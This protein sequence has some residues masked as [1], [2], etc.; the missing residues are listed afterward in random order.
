VEPY[1]I[2]GNGVA[3]V[4][5]VEAIRARGDRTP[6]IMCTD[7][8]CTFY[9]RPCLYYIMLGRIE[10][11]DAWGRPDSFYAE[12]GVDVRCSTRVSRIDPA[13]HAVE[14]EGQGALFY[15]R[16]LLA[17]GTRGRLLPWAAQ[18]LRGIV[19]LNM[20]LDV[21][22]IADLLAAA[23]HAVVAGGGLTSIEL[24]EVCRH[25]GVPATFVI[26]G[27]R[28]LEKQ[29]TNDE[30]ELV[31]ARLRGIG[32][33]LRLREEIAEVRGRDGRVAQAVM[34]TGEEIPCEVAGCTV[35]VV[36]NRELCGV[37]GGETAQGIVVDDGMRTSLPDVFAAGD[38]AQVQGPGDRAAPAEMLWYVAADMG[39]VAGANMAGGEE[40]Y[41][42]RVFLNVSEFCG[43]DFCGVG[44]IVPDQP[45]VE[46]TVIREG[47]KGSIRLVCR[48]GVLVGACFLGDIRLADLARGP[49]EAGA[50]P[51]DLG[52]DHPLRQLLERRSP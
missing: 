41:R 26:R 5:A 8:E 13:A 52:S 33:D 19:T 4:N 2:V 3:A 46:E 35:G 14:V 18:A 39:R 27:E 11:E 36:A 50:R 31:H 1:L 37:A 44:D 34:A 23:R 40:S 7:Q 49:I 22:T 20:L 25:W 24:V 30:A 9:S 45:E 12:H 16:L 32:V 10:W 48:G 21:R 6:I 51:R 43:L 15:S 29:L 38:V 17:V 28:F 47:S 42:R